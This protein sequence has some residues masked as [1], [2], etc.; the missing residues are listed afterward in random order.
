M[1]DK[2]W[3]CFASGLGPAR[4][5]PGEEP[6][7]RDGHRAR[8]L[9]GVAGQAAQNRGRRPAA[10]GKAPRTVIFIHIDLG[11]ILYTR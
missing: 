1:Y 2:L 9:Q 8:A 3:R 10:P 11:Q 4:G 5:E 6:Q 7:A